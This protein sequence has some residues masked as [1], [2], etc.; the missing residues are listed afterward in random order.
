M[1]VETLKS[2]IHKATVTDADLNMKE[3]S[4]LMKI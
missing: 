2:K 4:R 3:A 1:M